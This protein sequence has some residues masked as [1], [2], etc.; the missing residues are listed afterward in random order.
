[1]E[2]IK[3]ADVCSSSSYSSNVGSPLLSR[4]PEVTRDYGIIDVLQHYEVFDYVIPSF[5][6]VTVR[7][8]H[9]KITVVDKYGSDNLVC[10]HEWKC[11]DPKY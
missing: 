2:Q 1:M 7:L 8:R 9:I 3:T 11:G 5:S 10:I 4:S 6:V